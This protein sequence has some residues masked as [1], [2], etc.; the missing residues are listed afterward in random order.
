MGFD[1]FISTRTFADNL[2]VVVAELPLTEEE[3]PTIQ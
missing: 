3:P 1:E 2:P